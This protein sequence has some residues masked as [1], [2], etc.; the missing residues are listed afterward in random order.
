[1]NGSRYGAP[2]SWDKPI[3]FPSIDE[4][5]SSQERDPKDATLRSKKRGEGHPG[6]KRSVSGNLLSRLSFLR[7]NSDQDK[8]DGADKDG[9]DSFSTG[10]RGGPGGRGAMADAQMQSK[11]KRKGSLRKT[12]LGK[13][14]DRK[15]SEMRKSPLS[16]ANSTPLQTPSR[17][18]RPLHE[19]VW[20]YRARRPPN[21]RH[22]GHSGLSLE[23][24]FLPFAVAS[25][26]SIQHPLPPRL[27][28]LH[29]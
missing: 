19:Q 25:H 10:G 4:E 13:G 28:A 24:P 21:L 22:H 14:R 17:N 5:I 1:M 16:S 8:A 18:R 26:L 9:G 2:E 11:R 20:N 12:V 15:A 27:S 29:W 3:P 23:S 7:T 6:H